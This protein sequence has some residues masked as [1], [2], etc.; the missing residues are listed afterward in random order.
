ITG[1]WDVSKDRRFKSMTTEDYAALRR[2]IAKEMEVM[3]MMVNSGVDF[4]AGTDTPNPY[5]FP[6]FGIHDELA[7]M[8]KAGF[9]PMQALRAATINPARYFGWEKTMGSV[10]QG[11]VADLVLLDANPLQDIRNSTKISGVFVRGR[12]LDQSQLAGMIKKSAKVV[13]SGT[14]VFGFDLDDH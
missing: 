5:A 11:K 10:T 13:S 12:Y 9:T 8:V 2:R 7:L 6:G 4:L 3:A 1:T 14:P